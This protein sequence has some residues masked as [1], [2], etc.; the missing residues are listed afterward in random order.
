MSPLALCFGVPDRGRLR[1]SMFPP[2]TRLGVLCS[3]ARLASGIYVPE[4][5][6]LQGSTFPFVSRCGV[7]CS[8]TRLASANYVPERT[9]L[10]GSTFPVLSRLGVRCSGQGRTNTTFHFRAPTVDRSVGVAEQDWMTGPSRAALRVETGK[11]RRGEAGLAHAAH[12]AAHHHHDRASGP[13]RRRVW[14]LGRGV[15]GG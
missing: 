6:R 11:G 1:G 4:R 10:Q 9:G 5:A 15:G 3:R 2:A 14:G 7:L 8:R 12:R 13:A